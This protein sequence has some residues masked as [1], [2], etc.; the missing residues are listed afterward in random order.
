MNYKT[1]FYTLGMVIGFEGLC[2]FLPL[3][4][5]LCYGEKDWYYFLLC[6]IL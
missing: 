6:I 2:M 3:I 4:C 1:I 5:A